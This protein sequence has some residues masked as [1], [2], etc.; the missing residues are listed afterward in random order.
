MRDLLILFVRNPYPTE[1]PAVEQC[2]VSD[3]PSN[4]GLR[5][6]DRNIPAECSD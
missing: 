3:L 6:C 1:Q 5:A 4:P 2:E